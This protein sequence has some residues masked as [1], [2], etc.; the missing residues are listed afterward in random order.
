MI[1]IDDTLI[2]M[3]IKKAAISSRKRVHHNLHSDLN[4]KIHRLCVAIEPG[5]YIRPHRH[6]GSGKW[7][8]M[9]AMRGKMA[10]LLFDD[11]GKVTEK[12]ILTPGSSN[13]AVEI[14]VG[15][16]H[17]FVS[18]EKGSVI[19]EIKCGPYQKP[20]EYDFACW[21]SK[22]GELQAEKIENWFHTAK[23]GDSFNAV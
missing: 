1:V 15:V 4:D 8:L 20:E 10:V 22:E 13:S 19:F 21:A 5:S 12:V 23:E 9:I 17:T 2:E 18:L 11:V 16:W 14:P 3:L 6:S 7:E